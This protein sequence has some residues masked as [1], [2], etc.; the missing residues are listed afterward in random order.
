[1]KWLTE[2]GKRLL[3]P[4]LV[5]RLV[6]LQILLLVLV[7]IAVLL[8]AFVERRFGRSALDD[9][10]K[11]DTVIAVADDLA[12]QAGNAS[13]SFQ[14]L[15]R[16]LGNESSDERVTDWPFRMSVCLENTVIYISHDTPEVLCTLPVGPVTLLNE[17]DRS[18][19]VRVRQS[20]RSKVRVAFAQRTDLASLNPNLASVSILV[21]PLLVALPWVVLPAWISIRR[22]LRPLRR[23]IDE[24]GTRG[25]GKL[26]PLSYSPPHRELIGLVESVNQLMYELS[27]STTRE[28]A[29]V[30]DAAHE[31]R[32]PLAALRVNA[33]ALL[34]RT[35]APKDRELLDGILRSVVRAS[36]LA[37]QL[38][39]M[40]RSDIAAGLPTRHIAVNLGTL[41]RRRGRILSGLAAARH[42]VIQVES[43]EGVM[44]H[45]DV[46]GLASLIDNLLDNA[47]K[48]SPDQ[49]VVTLRVYATDE[50]ATLIVIDHGPGIPPHL[51]ERVFARFFRAPDQ[52]CQGGGLGLAIVKSVVDQHRGT[53]TLSDTPGVGLTA[54]VTLPLTRDT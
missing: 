7:W 2:W 50:Q 43:A 4:S 5:R 24:I 18:W 53:I 44:V 42:I 17:N 46:E 39:A 40:M 8:T 31:L 35:P 22:A 1:M 21:A 28:Q 12:R 23:V 51:R 54:T 49:A 37:N 34:L 33:E 30:A 6:V 16:L 9:T 32:T 11:F 41:S 25:P 14:S 15:D 36:R 10:V 29:F 48:Y 38:L 26:A 20:P 47:I 3:R 52:D 45:G 27:E 19:R 13:G